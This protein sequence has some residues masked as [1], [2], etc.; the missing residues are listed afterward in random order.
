MDAAAAG[1]SC[2]QRIDPVADKFSRR[3]K[4][5]KDRRISAAH[6]KW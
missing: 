5:I 6:P 1:R 3:K 4:K 2:E